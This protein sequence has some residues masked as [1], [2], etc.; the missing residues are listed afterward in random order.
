MR[1]VHT[2]DWHLGKIVNGFSM[3]EDQ[4]YYLNKMIAELKAVDADVLIMAGDLYDRVNPPKEAVQLA[5]DIFYRLIE[6]L[7]VKVLVIAG[8][9]DSP[10]RVAYAGELLKAQGLYTEGRAKEKAEKITIDNVNFW[11]L[12][13][14]DHVTLRK[15]LKDDSIQNLEDAFRVQMEEILGRLDSDEKNILLY[16]GYI[17]KGSP[18]SVEVSDSERP[19]SIGTAEYIDVSYFDVFDY[20]ALGHLHQGQKV[21]RETVRYSG[22]PLKYSKSEISHNKHLDIVDIEEEGVSIQPFFIEPLR[23]MRTVRGSFEELSKGYT[24]DYVFL[25]LT[26]QNVQLDGLQRLRKYYPNAMSLEY[27]HLQRKREEDKERDDFKM[28]EE[29][30]TEELFADFYERYTNRKLDEA[31]REI[32][33]DTLDEIEREARS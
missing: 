19:L 31:R 23:D 8:N 4:A 10:E 29:R 15:S 14:A 28:L 32:V 1:I 5:S 11:L 13:F 25:E 30:S 17:V 16:H 9:H 26:D 20:V 33:L 21:G 3:L 18:E 22:S 6:E 27:P 24:E 7:G 2:A 12:P